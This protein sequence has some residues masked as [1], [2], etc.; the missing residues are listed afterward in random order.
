MVYEYQTP[1][2]VWEELYNL[3]SGIGRPAIS[4]LDTV[5]TR[6]EDQKAMGT[7]TQRVPSN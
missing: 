1:I 6:C 5:L 4:F 7:N 3:G 2:L